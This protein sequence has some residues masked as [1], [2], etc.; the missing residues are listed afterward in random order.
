MLPALFSATILL[1]AALL[2]SIQPIIAK[3]LLPL[4]GGTPAVWTTCML[5]FQGALLAGYLYAHL[6][7][8]RWTMRGQSAVHLGLML[9]AGLVLPFGVSDDAVRSLAP[10]ANPAGWLLQG[11]LV[12]VGLPFFVISASAPLLQKWFSKT[13][14]P[15]AHDPYFLYA[16]SNLGS[17]AALLSYPVLIEP[18][19]RLVTQSQAWTAGYATLGA[20]FLLCAVAQARSSAEAGISPPSP[21]PDGRASLSSASRVGRV[22]LTSSGSPG[23]TRPTG[24][25]GREHGSETEKALQEPT[26]SPLPGGEPRTI[27][28]CGVRSAEFPF[29]NPHSE[30]LTPAGGA[31]GAF[32]R[33]SPRQ[34]F[35]WVALAF[36]PSSLMLGVTTYLTTDIA[37]IPL[38]WI[39]PLSLYLLTFVLAF[40][41][42]SVVPRGFLHRT[43]PFAAVGLIYLVLSE[44]TE[45]VALLIGIH[46]LF[47]FVAALAC[48]ARLADERPPATHL[49]EYYFWLSLGGV[50][51]GLFNAIVAPNIFRQVIEYPIA[52]VLACLLRRDKAREGS[53]AS[54]QPQGRASLSPASR[55]GLPGSWIGSPR[56]TCPTEGG[57]TDWLDLA[58]PAALGL[59]TLLLVAWIPTFKDLPVQL[60]LVLIFGPPLVLAATLA[61]R[62]LRFGFGLAAILLASS[63]YSGGHGRALHVERNFFGVLRV[64]LDPDGSFRRLVHGNTVH[65]RQFIDPARRSEPLSYYHRSG[66]L[67][68]IFRIFESKTAN[69][70]VAVV[71]LGA[72]SMASYARPHQRWTYFEINPGVIRVAQNTNYFTFLSESHPAAARMIVGDARLRLRE[73]PEKHFDLILIDAF[74]SDAIPAHLITREALEL[75][76]SKLAEGGFLVFHISNRCLDLEPVLGD[77]AGSQHLVCYAHDEADPSDWELAGGKDQSHWAVIA[78]RVEDLGRFTKDGRW[79][80][81]NS[82]RKPQVWTDDF[83]NIWS[84]FKWR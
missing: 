14:H 54:Y 82:R 34:R 38:L 17:L 77:L 22:P 58:L 41:R 6:L 73:A 61:D 7:S 37:S 45:P 56:R 49:T 25:M 8:R 43:T 65:G 68:Q 31:G 19:L 52:I 18:H 81:V 12:S 27:A 46:L 15:S 20:L 67:G 79:Q 30:F 9:L 62:P 35:F 10:D 83:S 40:A 78:R 55:I 60:R 50:L 59:L 42:R 76:L 13:G 39:L 53:P 21:E 1:S 24:F 74:S 48:H 57:F 69:T 36:V 28:E 33:P 70:N 75:Y 23:R 2:F 47:F 16:A 84:V 5:F 72:G 64:T 71:G 44:A 4:L 32:S 29:R 51:G 80:P 11:L 63:L 3:M 66:P 26:P